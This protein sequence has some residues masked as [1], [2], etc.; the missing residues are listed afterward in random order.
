MI[1]KTFSLVLLLTLFAGCASPD[2]PQQLVQPTHVLPTVAA[3]EFES[4]VPEQHVATLTTCQQVNQAVSEVDSST[5]AS[6]DNP[7]QESERLFHDLNEKLH[8]LSLQGFCTTNY[9]SPVMVLVSK[10]EDS[11]VTQTFC[12]MQIFESIEFD[13]QLLFKDFIQA[14]VLVDGCSVD[15]G[16]LN[17]V[18]ANAKAEATGKDTAAQSEVWAKMINDWA[19]QTGNLSSDYVAKYQLM[20]SAVKEVE[21]GRVNEAAF[22]ENG[23]RLIPIN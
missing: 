12:D 20:Q 3:D 7:A 16:A 18:L 19:T 11:V 6:S 13:N 5:I 9:H 4:T 15:F 1:H 23:T 17:I 8:T 21:I 14:V 22:D 10:L 2:T